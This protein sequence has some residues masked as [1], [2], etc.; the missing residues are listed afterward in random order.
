MHSLAQRMAGFLA[1]NSTRP[2]HTDELR[3]GI[4]IVLGAL[5]QILL[6]AIVAAV[7]G[8]LQETIAVMLTV[9]L[10]RRYTG[11]EHCEKYYRCTMSTLFTVLILGKA[12]A[13]F[14]ADYWGAGVGLILVLSLY[15]IDKVVPADNPV[16]RI[17]DPGQ[18]RQMKI[19]AIAVLLAMLTF[20][21]ILILGFQFNSLGI[22]ILLG[23]FWQDLTLFRPGIVYIHAWDKLFVSLERL[24]E[25]R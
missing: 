23:L 18:R 20:A 3:Y 12:A 5:L 8:L 2:V 14:P 21:S 13:L 24:W 9:L 6:V 7:A 15:L 16:L 25:R 11:G 22:A 1:G 10:Y 4:E 19:G 17:D